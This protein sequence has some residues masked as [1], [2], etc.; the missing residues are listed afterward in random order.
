MSKL[1]SASHG[2]RLTECVIRTESASTGLV[3]PVFRGDGGQG[4]GL[5]PPGESHWIDFC[6]APKLRRW[7][8]S[9][10]PPVRPAVMLWGLFTKTH[11]SLK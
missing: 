8:Q 1:F 6:R 5:W 3:V 2:A 7:C 9:H 11:N 4:L 10:K